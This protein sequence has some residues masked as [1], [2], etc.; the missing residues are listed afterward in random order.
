MGRRLATFVHESLLRGES[1]TGLAR[2]LAIG[3]Y[4]AFSPFIGMHTLMLIGIAWC[5]RLNFMLMLIFSNIINN[6]WTLVPVYASGYACGQALLSYTYGHAILLHNPA[7]MDSINAWLGS[8]L[9]V[10]QIS[11]WAFMLGG[12]ILGALIACIVYPIA[13]LCIIRIAHTYNLTTS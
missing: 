7:W 8:T 2:A 1:A 3:A 5:F 11:F 6:P 13:K 9:G 4:V 12:N 10:G